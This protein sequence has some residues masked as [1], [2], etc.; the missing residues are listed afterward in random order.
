MNPPLVATYRIQLGP[1][2]GFARCREVLPYLVRLGVSHIYA[3]P[4][5]RAR[6]GS[7]HGYDVCDHNAIN[8]ELGGMEEF[9]A[10]L[11]QAR[12]LGLA[13][14]QD[15]VPNHMAVSGDNRMLVDL[16]ENGAASRY[17]AFFDIDWEHPWERL[18]G[19]M[20]APFLGDF[21]GRTLERGEI[22]LRYD[23]EGFHVRYYD[24]R[25]PIRLDS[26][27]RILTHR[28]DRLHENLPRSDPDFVK[29]L[30]VL[31]TLKTLP[32]GEP[33]EERYGQIAFAKG[34]LHELY[35][36][37]APF[38][39]HVERNLAEFN[40]AGG[41]GPERFDLLDG[42]L[43]EQL[44]R[45]SSWKVAGQEINYRRFFSINHLIS[46][47]VEEE[48]VF[49]HTHALILDLVR[50]GLFAGLRVDHIDGLFDPSGYLRR[51]RDHAPE[52]HVWVEKVLIGDE[53]LPAFWPVQ[54]TTGYD[55]LNACQGLFVHSGHA[56]AFERIHAMFAGRRIT[57][58][59]VL[60]GAKAR[61]LAA[62]MAGDVD[63]MARLVN[64]VSGRDRHGFDITFNALKQAIA[65]LIVHFPVYRTY[66]SHGSFR[67]ADLSYIRQ[68]LRAARR[69]RPDLA[70]EFDFLERFLLLQ[71]DE[72]MCE[73]D[74]RQWTHF[75]M[76]FQQVTGPVMAKGMEDTA[77][78][79]A[80]RLL[81]LNEVGGDP[82]S[83]GA[84]P[85]AWDRFIRTRQEHW[86]LA[87][88]AT[89]THDTKRGED[90][91][92]RLAALSE[93]PEAWEE[94]LRRFSRITA[95]RAKATSER[96]AL[97]PNDLYLLFQSLLASWPFAEAKR[98]EFT[99]RFTAFLVKAVREGKEN[100]N[101]LS[102]HESYEQ[103]LVRFAQSILRP[104]RRNAFLR[105][106]TP[107]WER[108]ALH[109]AAVSLAQTLL[110]IAAPGVPDF[111]QGGELWDFS[112]V[113]PDN[114]RPVDFAART[115]L[116]DG[117][118]RDLAANP[119]RL[120]REL[121]A[122]YG[123]G[124]IKLLLI[125]RALAARR[126]HPELF[127]RGACEPLV[128]EGARAGQAF[129]FLRRS[130]EAAA[131]AV[132]PRLAAAAAPG[133]FP[134]AEFWE[135][136]RLLLPEGLPGPVREALTGTT[137]PANNAVYLKDALARLPAALILAGEAA[138]P[139]L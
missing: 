89:A 45:L 17:G 120:F 79:V 83:F 69:A 102:P 14:I 50:R 20:L 134:L 24:L 26:Y 32:T 15:I 71:F 122:R 41:Q 114:R 13:W 97:D 70:F 68:G 53:E 10:L 81:C 2:F 63:N 1:G 74:R 5:F 4:V 7:A 35:Q 76:R 37:C 119:E 90:A 31:Y 135:D 62:H 72:R 73:E 121:L 115:R 93:F 28:L 3:S 84:E 116:L 127:I 100:S 55:F 60:P 96:P 25:L 125:H 66:L 9:V 34:M 40:G 48:K 101:W 51:L 6:P 98:R 22:V 36:G 137:L 108:T 18:R 64:S 65:E 95:R 129:G 42:L 104:G 8:P 82:D 112:M 75:V 12:D 123:D 132:V 56:R 54:G 43:A 78:Y 113:D 110:K 21:Y 57:L 39:E 106:F 117:L 109:G 136:T 124:R 86:P 67:P 128:F 23:A 103:G 91:R 46:M 27:P 52:A 130:G 30:G 99:G 59:G 16:M 94:A 139:G 88:N 111:Y 29:L 61:I 77:F 33:P 38:C 133:R 87:L 58:A 47:R 126:R 44:F 105:E 19:R 49:K 118:E 131:L 85:E 80:N 92:A 107:L 138:G 11:E